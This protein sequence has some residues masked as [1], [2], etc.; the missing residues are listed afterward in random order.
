MSKCRS[1]NCR[2]YDHGH[3]LKIL[4]KAEKVSTQTNSLA[5]FGQVLKKVTLSIVVVSYFVSKCRSLTSREYDHGHTIKTLD[6]AEKV[7]AHPNTLAYFWPLI[8]KNSF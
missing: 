4:D 1:L 5:Y 3:S 7:Y 6:K 2:E 8:K